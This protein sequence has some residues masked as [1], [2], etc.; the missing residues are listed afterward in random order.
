MG[1]PDEG[2]GACSVTEALNIA[3]KDL[4]KLRLTVIGE[5]SELS[6]KRGYK[7]VYFTIRDDACALPCLIWND[8]YRVCGTELAVGMLV[9][10][11]GRFSCYPAKGRLQFS[12]DSIVPAGEG[13]LR[14]QVAQL[15]R[16]LEAEGLMDPARKRKLKALPQ[17]IGVV[18]SPRGKAIHDVIQTLRK[19]YPLAEL[20][21]Y[22]VKVEGV[23]AVEELISGL[24][25]ACETQPAPDVILLVRGGGT[26]EE[27]MPFNDERLARAVAACP[28]PVVTGI[29]HGP[30][31]SICDLVADVR[32]PT[33]TGAAE[34]VA[35][36]VEELAGKLGNATRALHSAYA[37]YIDAQ[38]GAVARLSD[39]QV[40]RDAHYLTGAAAQQLDYLAERLQRAIPDAV[41]SDARRVKD[42][43]QRLSRALPLLIGGHASRLET[44]RAQL[45]RAG[46]VSARDNAKA[47]ETIRQRLASAGG[48]ALNG[49]AASVALAAAKLDA[50]SPLKTLSRGYSITYAHDGHTVIDSV[51][52]VKPGDGISVQVQDG[53]LACTVDAVERQEQ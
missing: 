32:Q 34:A 50:L 37:S 43:A 25:C 47:L 1:K 18:T 42:Y 24:R 46:A 40:W 17:R 5:V 22:G 3:K 48:S 52:G 2:Q 28:I 23:G 15:A 49:H 36:S 9:E 39:R 45:L 16:K 12:A 4:E 26:Y 44:A 30:D 35:P 8:K 29:G 7:A 11:T 19:R 13:T 53:M 21:V 6:N 51:A 20:L 31:N 27:L 41:S 33:P 38:R 10:V 14:L